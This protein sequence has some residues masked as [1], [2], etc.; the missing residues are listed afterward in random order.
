ML[1]ISLD[2]KRTISADVTLGRGEYVLIPHTRSA[3][4]EV[5][6]VL[7]VYF[8]KKCGECVVVDRIVPRTD[9]GRAACL[10]N[11]A[12][13]E[14]RKEWVGLDQIKDKSIPVPAKP[15]WR[16]RKCSTV[17]I[18]ARTICSTC[19]GSDKEFVVEKRLGG[20]SDKEEKGGQRGIRMMKLLGKR[21]LEMMI[22]CASESGNQNLV[23]KVNTSIILSYSSKPPHRPKVLG[24]GVY[25]A[26]S[27]QT[28]TNSDKN[29]SNDSH[30]NNDSSNSNKSNNSISLVKR[31]SFER[32]NEV[33]IE[34][35]LQFNRKYYI[36]PFVQPGF[37]YTVTAYHQKLEKR[38]TKAPQTC[39]LTERLAFL[40]EAVC[41]EADVKQFREA[42][43]EP[44]PKL[45][46]QLTKMGYTSM[47]AKK[48]IRSNEGSDLT[49]I[50]DWLSSYKEEELKPAIDDSVSDSKQEE[51][52]AKAKT[53]VKLQKNERVGTAELKQQE[54]AQKQSDDSGVE[55]KLTSDIVSG[56]ISASVKGNGNG[57]G[58][59]DPAVG[60]RLEA[61]PE[62]VVGGPEQ[63]RS[64]PNLKQERKEEET[65][66]NNSDKKSQSQT[67]L[68]L[69]YCLKAGGYWKV[70]SSKESH[71]SIVQM[72]EHIKKI[73]A[74]STGIGENWI[75]VRVAK[76][77]GGDSGANRHAKPP[78]KPRA[79][80]MLRDRRFFEEGEFQRILANSLVR[81]ETVLTPAS[82]RKKIVKVVR[83]NPKRFFSGSEVLEVFE[84]AIDLK[85]R[86]TA[87][88][89]MGH[90]R[91]ALENA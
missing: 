82:T 88:E 26:G 75:A 5:A 70:A 42:V 13:E 24:L 77:E 90:L 11:V 22:N 58:D 12:K 18:P 40:P 7:K 91:R 72:D 80:D 41:I 31:S 61:V 49:Q 65:A 85:S 34:A 39:S 47:Q 46:E 32:A 56:S 79:L 30:D 53:D 10:V 17:N 38:R 62:V 69:F 87:E 59:S 27:E 54:G 52:G 55:G 35:D 8:E 74:G 57:V 25:A 66:I 16:C 28:D 84:A 15:H 20:K 76:V 51:S 4:T 29:T 50:L 73:R 71:D 60:G 89:A 21:C 1:T 6:Y 43:L 83:D 14:M 19:Y 33:V 78:N 86:Y 9:L 81:A 64:G 67:H 37:S 44:D 63:E 48:A 2:N 23:H 45:V 36:I 68:F 3:D